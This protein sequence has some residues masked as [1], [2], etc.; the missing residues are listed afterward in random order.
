MNILKRLPAW[1]SLALL[2]YMPFHIFLAQSVSLLTGGL[3]AWK[4]G[5]DVLLIFLTIVSV[6]LVYARA[7]QTKL[8]N[9]LFGLT[10]A[11]GLVH[12]IVWALNPDIFRE[13][14]LLGTLYNW[15]VAGFGL[16]GYGVS[17][18]YPDVVTRRRVI[19]LVL[20]VST[21][22]SLIALV[23]YFLP[24]DILTHFGYSL[25]RGVRPAFFIDDKPDLPR[26]M[27][28]MRDPNSL[29]AYLL[30]PILLLAAHL[31]RAKQKLLPVGL[32]VLHGLAMFLTFSRAAVGGLVVAAAAYYVL[33]W[34][35][36]LDFAKHK[37]RIALA[38]VA[39][40]L[41]G[42]FGYVF[43]DQYVVQNIILH[44]DESTQAEQDS[45]DLH[46]SLAV[47]GIKKVLAFP[48]GHGPGTAG[49]VSIRNQDGIMLTENYYIQIGYEV[50]IWGLALFLGL[51]VLIVLSLNRRNDEERVLIAI[52]VGYSA[53]AMLMHLWTNE[54]VAAQWWLAAGLA[55]GWNQK[56]SLTHKT[57]RLK[58]NKAKAKA[59]V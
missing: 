35:P 37:K 42:G 38:V 50:G 6:A 41:L 34:G 47:D 36:R 46:V 32:L 30:L 40:L 20:L 24:K 31:R 17:L 58:D 1:G 25:E 8:F 27:A 12:L 57:G 45:N 19:R 9:V 28:T 21:I 4:V 43:R 51:C 29:A 3:S 53:M 49:I 13:T 14:A 33:T 5:K 23:Q 39:V 15:R 52:F 10:F 56:H 44:S 18:L 11:Y 54:A 7:K 16:L 22:V 55:A 2:T 59:R 26:V 48:F